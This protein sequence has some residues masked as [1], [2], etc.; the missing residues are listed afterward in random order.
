MDLFIMVVSTAL[1]DRFK[2]I[3]EKI[4]SVKHSHHEKTVEFWMAI[5]EDYNKVNVLSK[6]LDSAISNIIFLSFANN[7][8][9]ILV[10]LLN[11]LE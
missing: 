2:Q 5:R 9:V 11:S 4:K 1:A 8:F 7:L 6:I 3:T 10:Q